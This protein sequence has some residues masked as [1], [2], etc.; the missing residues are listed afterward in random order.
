MLL[1]A[2]CL[3]ADGRRY[4]FLRR[5]VT[6][7]QLDLYGE[8]ASIKATFPT[9]LDSIRPVSFGFFWNEK[10]CVNKA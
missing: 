5:H 1:S 2:E 4:K 10:A 3:F 6:V 9:R 7:S 8:I